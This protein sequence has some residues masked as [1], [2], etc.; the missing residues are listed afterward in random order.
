M[1]TTATIFSLINLI[2]S[3]EAAYRIGFDYRDLLGNTYKSNTVDL[4]IY[5]KVVSYPRSC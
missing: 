3:G 5:K 2:G 1:A 4:G